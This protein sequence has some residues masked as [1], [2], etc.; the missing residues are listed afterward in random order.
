MSTKGKKL[1]VITR[2]KISLT[3]TIHTK[4]NLIKSAKTYFKHLEANPEELPTLAGYCLV[5]GIHPT[6]LT[7]YT[8]K[9]PE[10][11]QYIETIA[12]AQEQYCL[13]NGIKNRANP[14]FS[15]FLLKSKH[16]FLDQPQKLEQ[17]NTFNITPELMKDA[18]ELMSGKK[19]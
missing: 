1:S 13:I 5:A 2:G 19:K 15:M 3:K 9:Y 8:I 10:V 4:A 14:I 6:N 11:R 16:G 12:L 17:N 18:L 7:D